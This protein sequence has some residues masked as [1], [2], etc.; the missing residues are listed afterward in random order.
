MTNAVIPRW[1][2]DNYQA[3]IFWEYALHLLDSDSCIVEV[4]FEADGPKAFDD[5]IVKYNPP[6]PRSSD[7]RIT[8][9]YHQVKWHVEY[10]G[11]FGYQE[12]IDPAFI[13]AQTISLLERLKKA[14]QNTNNASNFS[15]VT[16]YRIKDGDPLGD[17]VS[18]NDKSI[19]IE[20]LFDDTTDKSRMGK[21]RKLWREH[22]ELS[23]DQELL[24]IIK[25]F[26]VIEGHKSL[27]ELRNS[28]NLRAKV[29]GLISCSDANS[30]FRYD[31]LARQLKIRKLN[32]FTRDT[33]RK[34]CEEE[35]LINGSALNSSDRLKIAIR[36]FLGIA[37]DTVD[38]RLENTLLLTA[39]FRQRYLRDDL[40][41]QKDI[42]PLIESFL[43]AAIHKSKRLELILDAHASIAFLCGSI[44]NLKSGVDV[45]LIQKGRVGNRV[46]RADDTEIISEVGFQTKTDLL[47]PGVE[48][49]VIISISQNAVIQAKHYISTNLPNIGKVL[50]FDLPNGPGQSVIASGK[51][52]ALLAD[53]VSNTLR[54]TKAL[55]IDGLV[56]IFAACP[57][58]FLF[59]MGQSAQGVTPCIIYEF[60][61]DRKGNKTYQPSFLID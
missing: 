14:V 39:Q 34:L 60:D 49:A 6:V 53:H 15:F 1:H 30:D 25:G 21:V 43:Q 37:S 28:I 47:G 55:N 22:L 20:K 48:I 32:S 17:L 3:R 12:F 36:S 50:M 24:S 44:L 40:N 18:G 59:F 7:D 41:W 19:L 54:S 29:V 58:S 56:H 5:V 13:G 26:R 51:H 11:R 52:A 45:S 8:A 35:S 4:S 27:E 33:F 23:S 9:D 46:W 2:G 31:E 10:G 16:T 38:A 57:N 61:F 42:R